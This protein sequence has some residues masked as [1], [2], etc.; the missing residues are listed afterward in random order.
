M[1]ILFDGLTKEE[2]L[3]FC[4]LLLDVYNSSSKD[5]ETYY[6]IQH[7]YALLLKEF[8]Y[9]DRLDALYDMVQ[10]TK[11][12]AYPNNSTEEN[13]PHS[14]SDALKIS[15]ESSKLKKVAETSD[16]LNI[17][18]FLLMYLEAFFGAI[19][20]KL[21]IVLSD[22]DAVSQINFGLNKLWVVL[23]LPSFIREIFLSI[24]HLSDGNTHYL[25]EHAIDLIGKAYW[26]MTG[27]LGNIPP[28]A[29]II[30]SVIG[31]AGA[32]IYG[33]DSISVAVK[34]YLQ[35]REINTF[36]KHLDNKIQQ[37]TEKISNLKNEVEQLT[38][39]IDK[40]NH[41]TEH[42]KDLNEKFKATKKEL[43]PKLKKIHKQ[44]Q[45]AVEEKK[46]ETL[47]ETK[48]RLICRKSYIKKSQ[49]INF[50]TSVALFAGVGISFI[51]PIAGGVIII[52]ACAA[53]YYVD[54]YYL[55]KEEVRL[56]YNPLELLHH[57]LLDHVEAQILR[58]SSEKQLDKK[59]QAPHPN[60]KLT[61][62]MDVRDKLFKWQNNQPRDEKELYQLLEIVIKAS[63]MKRGEHAP[64][65]AA[66]LKYD[67]RAFNTN[68]KYATCENKESFISRIDRFIND[69]PEKVKSKI[70]YPSPSLFFEK[71]KFKQNINPTLPNI[72]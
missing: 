39:E 37:Q 11:E 18:L 21:D 38:E 2:K 42:I 71:S 32:I 15:G 16:E 46:L 6:N 51:N 65:S 29:A 56:S 23:F 64:K 30:T 4:R 52:A 47:I 33:L 20:N 40:S 69:R 41:N 66:E 35:I 3:D 55:P 31:P 49:L 48:E 54:N 8:K 13:I 63:E 50:A 61:A 27:V 53:Q 5:K 7:Q 36:I 17:L 19:L 70:T 34:A 43:E 44:N 67:L 22:K 26:I 57:R 58:L 10:T 9:D 24:K 12:R 14:L 45:L 68:W 72:I 1:T 28:V 25:K 62:Y 59:C 60:P